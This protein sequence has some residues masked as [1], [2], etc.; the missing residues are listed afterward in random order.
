MIFGN[1]KNLSEYS[2]LEEQIKECFDYYKNNDL[3]S[4]EK[5]SHEIDGQRLFVNIVEYTT[6]KPE[7]RFWEAHK[8]YLD[9]HLM[10]DGCEQIDLNF[11]NNMKLGEFVEKDDFLPMEGPKNSSVVLRDGDFL[12]C[13]PADG[14]MTAVAVDEPQKIKK[15]IFKIQ[16]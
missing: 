4:F 3:K 9:L 12:I 8:N 16:I 1:V 7:N 10:L 14:H 2:Y 13:Y 11:I 5:G 15:A 6:T